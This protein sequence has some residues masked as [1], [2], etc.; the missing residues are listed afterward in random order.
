MGHFE[1]KYWVEGLCFAPM[2][3]RSTCL[4]AASTLH[5]NIASHPDTG[6]EGNVAADWYAKDTAN[7][8]F[9]G[10]VAATVSIQ[11]SDCI[12]DSW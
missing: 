9:K 4:L 5:V 3:V 6:I 10:V 1:V 11:S 8:L 12:Q 2:T 7:E